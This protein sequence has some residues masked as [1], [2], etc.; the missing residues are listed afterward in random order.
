MG[1]RENLADVQAR[2]RRAAQRSGRS[3]DEI[4]CWV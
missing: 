4:G 1:I 2:I 3:V